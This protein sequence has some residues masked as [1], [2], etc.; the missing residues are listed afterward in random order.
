MLILEGHRGK[1]HTLAFS[2]DGRTLASVAGRSSV[3]WLWDLESHQRRGELRGHTHRVVSLAFA[4]HDADGQTLASADSAGNVW[5]WDAADATE[6]EQVL[7]L[8]VGGPSQPVRIAFSPNGSILAGTSGNNQ[9]VPGRYWFTL[10]W[11]VILWRADKGRV[12]QGPSGHTEPVSCLAFAPVG[13]TLATGSFDRSV[14]LWD[15]PGKAERFT[16]DHAAKVHF[17]AFTPDGST[18]ASASPTGLVKLWDL[19]TGRKRTTLQG[20]GKFLHAV[21]YSPD[22]RALATASG[23]GTVR[24]WD[25]A[26]GQVRS[27]LDFRIGEAHAVAFAPDG[28]RA[29]VG[30]EGQ[31][32]IWDIDDWDG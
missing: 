28:M 20:Q 8:P 6:R 26:T 2:A 29:A 18:L 23:D 31:I 11:G 32:I 1:V 14:K 15:F 16:L 27:A 9:R 5:L 12:E 22:G 4:P 10:S 21:C 7:T 30:G 19:A 13:K 3:I 24:L 25:V 17:L